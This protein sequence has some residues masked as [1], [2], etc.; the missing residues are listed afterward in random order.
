MLAYRLVA[1]G[2]GGRTVR[3]LNEGRAAADEGM[4]VEEFLTWVAYLQLEPL[5]ETRADAH[6]AM[7]MAQTHNMN[8]GKGRAVKSPQAFYPRWY[9]PPPPPERAM[10]RNRAA[11]EAAFLAMRGDP[12]KL[13]K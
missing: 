11:M 13:G 10:E 9:T 2:I 7:L 1:H 12:K 8:R 5:P 3:E 4:D 6:T